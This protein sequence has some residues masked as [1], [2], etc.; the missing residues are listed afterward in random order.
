VGGHAHKIV[1]DRGLGFSDQVTLSG[2]NLPTDTYTANWAFEVDPWLYRAGAGIR[3][4]WL[5]KQ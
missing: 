3:F 5:G 2:S 1:S 4:H